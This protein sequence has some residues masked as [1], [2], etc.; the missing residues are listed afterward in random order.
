MDWNCLATK[1]V[2][3]EAATTV[4]FELGCTAW[5]GTGYSAVPT[6]TAGG[7]T[8]TT[9]T[10][11]GLP[12]YATWPVGEL[13]WV[14]DEPEDNNDDKTTTCNL[15][16]FFICISWGNIK[17]GGWK[18]DF[19]PGILSP[20]PPPTVKFPPS[21]SIKGN[22]PGPWP[23]VTIGTNGVATYP[24]EKPTDCTSSTAEVCITTTS[25]SATVTGRTTQTATSV[26]STCTPV[27]GC[28]VEN[29]DT[30]TSVTTRA[31]CTA[32]T[33][34]GRRTVVADVPAEATAVSEKVA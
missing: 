28:N 3:I 8:E 4:N 34:L 14:E 21:F 15:W 5:K 16:F 12:V 6:G 11:S 22:L 10:I 18:W 32:S 19:P 9:S 33:Y 27:V 2:E 1:T 25:F 26:V 24:T 29:D 31:G 23:R 13:I 20:G 30:T 7:D 17:I